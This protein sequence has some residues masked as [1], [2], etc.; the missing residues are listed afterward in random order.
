MI[1]ITKEEEKEILALYPDIKISKTMK[2]HSKGKRGK[3]YAP[4]HAG[5]IK[6]L[7]KMR[8]GI[9]HTQNQPKDNTNN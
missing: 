5:I 9:T 1:L 6:L 3:R 2:N 4:P 8:N 7:R